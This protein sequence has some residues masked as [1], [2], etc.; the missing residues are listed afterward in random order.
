MKQLADI[1]IVL[2]GQT[3]DL[4]PADG[5]L[6]ALR[7]VTGTVPSIPLIA[8]SIM[9]KKIAAGAQKIVLDVKTGVGAFMENLDEARELAK[10]MVS[11]G[12]LSGREVVALLSDMN[13]P[14]GDA[15][16]NA[17]E[18]KEAVETLQGGGPKDFVEHCLVVASHMLVLGEKAADL[19]KA[20]LMAE[21]A[22]KSG[23]AFD[24]FKQLV[25]AQ[26][27]SVKQ[28]ED[29]SLLPKAQFVDNV[30][31]AST[32]W[33]SEVNARIVGETSVILGAGR[34]KKTD[35]ID[36][37]VGIIVQKKVGDQVESGDALFTVHADQEETLQEAMRILTDAV[38]ISDKPVDE[39]PL[40]Y[41]VIS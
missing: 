22:L 9:S 24:K 32:G 15:V 1:G 25:I 16:G 4:A 38:K 23:A 21:N 28:I 31:C 8:S 13:Q 19:E 14:L 34:Q 36:H 40:F 29:L 27:G 30:K 17:L 37:A 35:T 12:A 39:L 10:L 7:D 20:R 26:G 5:K 2:A 33:V 11:I 41:G 18:L 3:G 6:Y